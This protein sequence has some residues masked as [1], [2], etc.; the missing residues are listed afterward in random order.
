VLGGVTGSGAGST[1]DFYLLKLAADADVTVTAPNGGETWLVGDSYNITWTSVNVPS[2]QNV[3]IELNRAYPGPT[4]E[5]IIASTP[6]DGTHPWTVTGPATTGARVRVTGVE[7]AWASDTSD[8]NFTITLDIASAEA[9]LPERFYS[10][11]C[12]SV[13]AGAIEIELG[14]PAASSVGSY[15]Y[16]ARGR[17]VKQ[18]AGGQVVPSGV[19]VLSWD[20]RNDSGVEVSAGV[21]FIR[22]EAGNHRATHRAVVLN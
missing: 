9:V 22:V 15:V 2:S 16:D 11:V 14:L 18:L 17:V 5:T 8:A 12:S 20:R 21:Y 7:Q 4:W 19:H 6:N 3:K 1:D 10:S 13:G